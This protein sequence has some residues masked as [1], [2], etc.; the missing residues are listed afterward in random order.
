MLIVEDDPIIAHDLSVVLKKEQI[1]ISGVAHSYNNALDL[2]VN[3]SFDLALLDIN[4]G[5]GKSGI[6]IAE[7]IKNKHFKPFVFLTS[8][9]DETTLQSAQEK[10]PF[11][12]LVKPFQEASLLTTISLALH[13]HKS[14]KKDINFQELGVILTKQ[15][16]KICEQLCK[17]KTY[18]QI[19]ENEFVSI[20]TVRFHVKNLYLKFEVKGRA[21]LVGKLI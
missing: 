2:L 15:E 18:Q 13:A 19:A 20:N 21:E 1:R 4:L 8:Y 14:A 16:Q 5:S 11:G 17:G 10:G 6:D 7:V 3:R 9:S 12:Y